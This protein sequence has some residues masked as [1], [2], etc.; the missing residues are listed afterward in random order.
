MM[1]LPPRPPSTPFH[2]RDSLQAGNGTLAAGAGGGRVWPW[3]GLIGG[4]LSGA[5]EHRRDLF[6][7][8]SC[9]RPPVPLLAIAIGP[10]AFFSGE[11]GRR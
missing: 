11:G 5:P 6:R 10:G 7:L 4:G 9:R 1:I 2:D 3:R 8:R